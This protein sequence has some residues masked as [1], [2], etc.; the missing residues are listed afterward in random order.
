MSRIHEALKKAELAR[1]EGVS[2][3]V[4]E[5]PAPPDELRS[6][7]HPFHEDGTPAGGYLA[8]GPLSLESLRQRCTAG[9][10]RPDAKAVV[11]A[12]VTAQTHPSGAEEFR[13][14]RSRLEHLREKQAL[15]TL[16]I[17][18]A[19]PSEGKTFVTLNL[20]RAIAQQSHRSVLV[21]DGD[22]RI[23][24]VHEGLGAALSPGLTEYL[25]GEAE[26]LDVIQRGPQDNL[27][28]IAGGATN[29]NPVELLDTGRLRA[30]INLFMPVFDWILVDSPPAGFLSDSSLLAKVSDGVLLVV[31]S[32]VTP[33]DTAQKSCKEFPADQLVGVVLNRVPPGMGY[34]YYYYYGYGY[35]SGKAAPRNGHVKN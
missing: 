4:S 11:F 19:L 30:L 23:S 31:Q 29:S 8:P 7:E 20:A 6:P 2:V 17:T 3:S 14:L 10:W 27:F 24:R 12:D 1:G 25:K 28:V 22:L 32:G 16:L 33:Y 21:I 13:T 18:S 26:A 34:G 15:Q 9:D 35:G 5:S